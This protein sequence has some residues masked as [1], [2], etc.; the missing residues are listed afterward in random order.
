MDIK[1]KIRIKYIILFVLFTAVGLTMILTFN[2]EDARASQAVDQHGHDEHDHAAEAHDEHAEEGH[3]EHEG[4]DERGDGG[5]SLSPEAL[6]DAGIVV[7]KLE[8]RILSSTLE[9]PGEAMPHPSAEGFVGSLVEGRIK[10][11]F[12]DVGDHIS[13]G[14]ALCIIESPAIGEAEAAYI[15]S[16][17]ERQF[18]QADLER[19]N[20]LISEGI[21]SQKEVAELQAAL[22]SSASLVSAA[23]ITLYAYG[24]NKDDITSLE[25]DQHIG[26]RVTLRSPTSGTLIH[27]DVRLGRQVTP[28]T[29]LFHIVNL[30]KLRVHID[31]PEKNICDITKGMEVTIISQNRNQNEVTGVIDRLGGS[32]EHETRS[33]TVFATVDNSAGLLFPGAFVMVRLLIGNEGHKVLAVPLEAV[34]KDEHGDQAL[35]VELQRGKFKMREV[36]T[37]ISAGGWIEITAGVAAGERVVTIG[38]FAVK[39][40]ADKHKFGDGH[41]H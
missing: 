34:F 18:L 25:S 16:R 31:I 41:G 17:A 24:F 35:F 4:H 40:E 37:G 11:I 32:I 9:L 20:I 39:S 7:E 2:N 5:I 26:G 38:S 21:G 30:K 13:Q 33:L 29:D 1:M 23:K 22:A 8:P 12:V 10:G 6:K 3:D 19:H 28:E 15:T 36:E 14:V 27:R